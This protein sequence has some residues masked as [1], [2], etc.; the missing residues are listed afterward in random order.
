MLAVY[1]VAFAGVA[2]ITVPAIAA[3][4]R[5]SRFTYLVRMHSNQFDFCPPSQVPRDR[6]KG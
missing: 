2:S 1:G 5:V 6:T 4:Q 3:A